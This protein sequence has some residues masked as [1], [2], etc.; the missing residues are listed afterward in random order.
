MSVGEGST[1]SY[2]ER[3]RQTLLL[4]GRTCNRILYFL[5]GFG[6]HCPATGESDTISFTRT[7]NDVGAGKQADVEFEFDKFMSD[8]EGV[9]KCALVFI[10]EN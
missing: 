7:F 4:C 6:R 2:G 1:R 9:A 8:F 10:T 3:R 5:S